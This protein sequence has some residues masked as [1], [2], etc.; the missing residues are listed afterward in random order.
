MSTD[1]P[2]SAPPTAPVPSEPGVIAPAPSAGAQQAYSAPPA[3]PAPPAYAP[4]LGSAPPPEKPSGLALAAIVLT[5]AYAA[6]SVVS[7]LLTPTTVQNIK[8]AAANPDEVNF[9][10]GTTVVG[11]LS[12]VLALGAFVFLAM[13]MWRIRGNRTAVGYTPGGPPAVEWWG[14]FIPVANFV[15]PALGMRAITK[16]I[17][18]IGKLLGW[19][20]PFCLTFVATGFISVAQFFAIDFTTREVT[21]PE[22][23][24]A[25]VPVAWLAAALLVVSWL[26][27]V[28]IIRRTTDRHLEASA[29]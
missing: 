27:L 21:H 7:A 25:M 24:D 14:W 28:A 18:G 10:V 20:V 22:T 12:S 11:L 29:S 4:P 8:D 17:V 9:D 3:Y 23:L 5:G 26:F 6:G 2:F 1:D 13:W 16:G 19:W 15:L